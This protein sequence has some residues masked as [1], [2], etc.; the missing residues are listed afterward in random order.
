MTSFDRCRVCDTWPC[1]CRA[2]DDCDPAWS[3]SSAE[4]VQVHEPH[5]RVKDVVIA[6]LLCVGIAAILVA[7]FS[8]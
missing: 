4:G 7:L 2:D 5:A 6:G 8:R 3:E 1:S